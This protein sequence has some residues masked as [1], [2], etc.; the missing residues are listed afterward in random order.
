M[1][2]SWVL[3]GEDAAGERRQPPRNPGRSVRTLWRRRCRRWRWCLIRR[4][5]APAANPSRSSTTTAASATT[6]K[7]LVPMC[8]AAVCTFTV[9]CG[10]TV[11]RA[12][13]GLSCVGYIVAAQPQPTAQSSSRIALTVRRPPPS[14]QEGFTPCTFLSVAWGA[15]GRIE[16]APSGPAAPSSRIA[17]SSPLAQNL[18]RF[19]CI[20]ARGKSAVRAPS[21]PLPP[22]ASSTRSLQKDS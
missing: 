3:A 19:G 1:R 7:A 15:H 20:G 2:G 13:A 4:R 18:S 9:P 14:L 6:V 10:V 21:A 17:S 5:P 22:A 12:V 11:T 16:E 8:G